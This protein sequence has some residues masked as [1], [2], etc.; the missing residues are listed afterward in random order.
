MH[1]RILIYGYMEA[2]VESA[3]CG[4]DARATQVELDARFFRGL[5]DPTRVRILEH[6]L[7]GEKSVGE[8]VECLDAPQSSVS[9][10]LGCLRWC[11]YVSA[12]KEG[13]HV[14]YQVTDARVR[15][16]LRLARAIIV[17]NAQA[18]LSCQVIR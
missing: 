9:M 14:Y 17:D 15:E 13:R 10:H 18:I 1:R 2:P 8:I 4:L 11:G 16:I 12:R 3:V 7:E 5:G 6:L